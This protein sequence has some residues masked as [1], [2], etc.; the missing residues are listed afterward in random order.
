MSSVDN[1]LTKIALVV[2]DK[3]PFYKRPVSATL[4][5]L[6]D[7]IT[8]L[9]STS[10]RVL[11]RT[12]S[13]E[14]VNINE[15]ITALEKVDP[16]FAKDLKI[17]LGRRRLLD[18]YKRIFT[19]KR[20]SLPSKLY[21]ALL[22]TLI[23]PIAALQRAD[24]YDPGA[25]EVVLYH[26]EPAILAHELGHA[27]DFYRKKYPTLY[28]LLRFLYP[29]TLF[30]EYQA[31]KNAPEYFELANLSEAEKKRLDRILTAALGTYIGAPFA[32]YGTLT[33]GLAGAVAG[34]TGR[35]FTELHKM[36]KA[37]KEKSEKEKS[38][39]KEIKKKSKK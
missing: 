2:E 4:G 36:E 34:M 39:K 8:A 23:T 22:N 11:G 31:S 32:P 26:S 14:D 16:D 37:K 12:A 30:Q 33:G 25:H 28:A 13:K 38:E 21:W 19:S 10:L 1:L 20:I 5:R 15:I 3:P 35:P 29:G 7:P 27:E 18:A 17:S 6:Q 24:Y 9:L